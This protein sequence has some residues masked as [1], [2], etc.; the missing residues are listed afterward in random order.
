MNP[1]QE[2]SMKKIYCYTKVGHCAESLKSA[3]E[4]AI[5]NYFNESFEV[6]VKVVKRFIK[7]PESELSILHITKGQLDQGHPKNSKELLLVGQ[8]DLIEIDYSVGIAF[9][10]FDHK[11]YQFKKN[12]LITRP[13][14]SRQNTK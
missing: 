9:E 5:S 12:I 6:I 8:E 7:K 10:Q 14:K 3:V 13:P 2:M 1:K 4:N 11:N